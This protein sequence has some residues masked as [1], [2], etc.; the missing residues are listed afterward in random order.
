MESK[1]QTGVLLVLG[2]IIALI[3]WMGFYPQAEG[4]AEIAKALMDDPTMGTIGSLLGYTG[5]ITIMLGL[6]YFTSRLANSGSNGASYAS[7]PS[8][9][10]LVMIAFFISGVGLELAT[11]QADSLSQGQ[12][13]QEITFAMGGGFG[14][15][16]GGGLLLTAASVILSKSYHLL[17]GAIF[18]LPGIILPI[19]FLTQSGPNDP[20]SMASWMSLM[21][22]LVAIG[23]LDIRSARQGNG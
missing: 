11:I 7:V 21:F 20:I 3:G 12:L 14:L 10:F 5:M 17:V 6:H 23:I 22:G 19:S 13:Y 1:M 16:V 2:P 8:K 18:V 15:V 4:P 9:L